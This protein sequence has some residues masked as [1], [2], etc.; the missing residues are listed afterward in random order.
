MTIL[1]DVRILT[2]KKEAWMPTP[3]PSGEGWILEG[4]Q[5]HLRAF[6]PDP[7]EHTLAK[8]EMGGWMWLHSGMPSAKPSTLEADERTLCAMKLRMYLTGP[9]AGRLGHWLYCAH[10][11]RNEAAA[12][13]KEYRKQRAI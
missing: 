7:A 4:G 10:R 8:L 2:T 13:L 9:Q 11:F 1:A 3:P 5:V 12:W 6:T